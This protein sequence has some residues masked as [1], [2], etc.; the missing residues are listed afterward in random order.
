MIEQS[1]ILAVDLCKN[2][3]NLAS[4]LGPNAAPLIDLADY[5]VSRD[6]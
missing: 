1:K 4:Q 3:Q 2:A 6:H 5:L